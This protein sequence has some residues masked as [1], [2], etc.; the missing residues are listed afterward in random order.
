MEA[1]FRGAHQ[2]ALQ[3]RH[4]LSLLKTLVAPMI[5]GCPQV[6]RQPSSSP[7]AALVCRKTTTQ[8]HHFAVKR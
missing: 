5:A 3:N 6:A 4:L 1:V 8:C 2:G 7:P